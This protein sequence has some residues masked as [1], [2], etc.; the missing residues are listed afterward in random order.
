MRAS[1][2]ALLFWSL[3][4]LAACGK[5]C[6]AAGDTSIIAHEGTPVGEEMVVDGTT[7]YVSKPKCKQ[8]KAAVLYLTD[9]FGIQ[10]AQNKLYTLSL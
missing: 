4:P 8:P 6:P 7:F 9:V 10:L 1:I 2:A 5:E 3:S